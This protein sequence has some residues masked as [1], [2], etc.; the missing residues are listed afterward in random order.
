MSRDATIID[1]DGTIYSL[2]KKFRFLD[3]NVYNLNNLIL[4]VA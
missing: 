3:Y 4:H 1:F 2:R